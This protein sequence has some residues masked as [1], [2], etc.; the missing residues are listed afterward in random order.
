MVKETFDSSH[1]D[2]SLHEL[3]TVVEGKIGAE[4]LRQMKQ[5]IYKYIDRC[6]NNIK[7]DYNKLNE[8]LKHMLAQLRAEFEQHATGPFVALT[9]RVS[10][11]EKKVS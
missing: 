8:D 1:L 5:D 7:T 11:L 9:A 10:A 4:E 6:D 2:R 3:K